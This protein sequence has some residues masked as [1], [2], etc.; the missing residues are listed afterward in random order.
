[1]TLGENKRY[2]ELRRALTIQ[3]PQVS[4]L[5]DQRAVP[6]KP[7]DRV[8]LGAA[9]LKR[10]RARLCLYLAAEDAPIEPNDPFTITV[11]QLL[12]GN[13]G[14][15]KFLLES[16]GD[17]TAMRVL[18]LK[19]AELYRQASTWRA[20]PAE[21]AGLRQRVPPRPR[22]HQPFKLDLAGAF[23]TAAHGLGLTSGASVSM[24]YR[25]NDA[26]LIELGGIV[27]YYVGSQSPKGRYT[28]HLTEWDPAVWLAIRTPSDVFVGF[29]VRAGLRVTNAEATPESSL[30]EKGSERVAVPS[31]AG[32]A[33]MGTLFGRF[34][35]A[36]A[37]GLEGTAWE[38]RFAT[39]GQEVLRLTQ[40]SYIATL[41]AGLYF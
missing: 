10:H 6:T 1:M 12:P 35:V 27:A 34:E 22:E 25:H 32:L 41:G 19:L 24:G 29:E 2:E 13:A 3:L 33:K 16:M 20:N 9:L 17:E 7:S 11:L 5:Q 23:R 4:W 37:V 26:S 30:A 38:Q 40:F 14:V 8:Q 18:A 21:P 39:N 15:E 36:A 31:L 28:L